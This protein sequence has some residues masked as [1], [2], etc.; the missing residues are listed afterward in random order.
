MHILVNKRRR[1]GPR[2]TP[3]SEADLSEKQESRCRVSDDQGLIVCF[4]V[5]LW[6]KTK[7]IM[8]EKMVIS[9]A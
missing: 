5:S 8:F 7:K 6:K 4:I 1:Q 3:E 2:A 9:G